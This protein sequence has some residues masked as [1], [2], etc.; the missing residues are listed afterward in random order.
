MTMPKNYLKQ[1][2]LFFQYFFSIY[3]LIY[4][5]NIVFNL[6]MQR[7]WF[8]TDFFIVF[9]SR[10]PLVSM[11]GSLRYIFARYHAVLGNNRLKLS[12][13]KVST[14]SFEKTHASS[15]LAS[16]PVLLEIEYQKS[17]KSL[18]SWQI[19]SHRQGL[20]RWFRFAQLA[21][22]KKSRP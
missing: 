7:F 15:I 12:I 17:R 6:P 1:V 18:R 2:F 20:C 5:I 16:F 19:F 22:G 9:I 21:K 13:L 10:G 14:M 11:V 4:I 8:L 3:F